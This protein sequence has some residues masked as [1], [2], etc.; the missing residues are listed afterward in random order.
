M[1]FLLPDQDAFSTTPESS[2]TSR[3]VLCDAKFTR[4]RSDTP[5][6]NNEYDFSLIINFSPDMFSRK[7][8]TPNRSNI[9]ARVLSFDDFE[10]EEKTDSDIEK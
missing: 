10:V 7:I 1:S 3:Q 8:G 6:G 4:S 9:A 5:I 2:T